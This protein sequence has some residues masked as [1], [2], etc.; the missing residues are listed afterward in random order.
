MADSGIK[1]IR[2]QSSDIP[3]PAGSQTDLS[4]NIRYRVVSEDKNRNSHWS[5]FYKLYAE[6]TF[7][8]VG[9]DPENPITSSIP[10]SIVVTKSSHQIELTWTMPAL[11]IASPTPEEKDMQTKQA[12]I[13]SF[14]VYVQWKS[15][16][17]PEIISDWV[18]LRTSNSSRYAMSYVDG[19]DYARFRVQK[20]T[21]EKQAWNAATYLITDWQ[22]L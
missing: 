20:V 6:T 18:W 19:Q 8:E 10:N 2:I 1:K 7:D 3:E 17:N 4:Y 12:S 21:Q 13:K 16:N 15:G 11:L 14:D 22:S 9:W 5:Q